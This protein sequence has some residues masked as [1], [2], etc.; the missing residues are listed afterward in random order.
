MMSARSAWGYWDGKR[1]GLRAV[2]GVVFVGLLMAS[3]GCIRKF[4]RANYETISMHMDE[5]TVRSK[6]GRPDREDGPAWIYER[7]RPYYKA[8][9]YFRNGLVVRKEWYPSRDLAERAEG[10][11]G[12]DVE[13]E[14]AEPDDQPFI[15]EPSEPVTPDSPPEDETAD[16]LAPTPLPQLP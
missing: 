7:N 10:E 11:P 13:V 4:N 1:F 6:L 14:M 15:R 2:A 5:Y 3:P 12:S 8:V 16:P 9:I